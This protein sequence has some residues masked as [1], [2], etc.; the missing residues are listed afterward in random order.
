MKI[1][2]FRGFLL[3]T[4][5]DTPYR[6]WVGSSHLD[7]GLPV[8]WAPRGPLWALARFGHL[9]PGGLSLVV[10]AP[11]TWILEGQALLGP[12][13]LPGL[14]VHLKDEALAG[15]IQGSGEAAPGI[16]YHG[17]EPPRGAAGEAWRRGWTGWVPA[18]GAGWSLPGLGSL[19]KDADPAGGFL[20]GEALVPLGAL[21]HLE[22]ADLAAAISQAQ[23]EL[24]QALSLRLGAGA[25]P[26]AFPFHRRRTGWRVTFLG[27]REAQ[28]AG[29]DWTALAAQASTLLED[30]SR[31]L[32]CPVHAGAGLDF[33]AAAIL[34]HQA[35]R[36]GLPWRG[37]LP[38]PPA[39]ATF[40]PGLGADPREPS[41]LEARAAYP[42]PMAALLGDPPVALLRMPGP[43]G[44]PGA[45]AFAGGL[46][47]PPAICW[48]PPELPPPGPFMTDRTWAPSAAFPPLAD[49]AL[50]RQPSL[51]DP[52]DL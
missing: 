6:G 45:L 49:T 50:A 32:R 9:L 23:A 35:M 21:G 17:A 19:G 3:R 8:Q 37:T 34:G 33:E 14:A 4:G 24:E 46:S 2:E 1:H 13:P 16:W 42:E 26:Q 28:T 25:W 40:S 29:A 15:A 5:L 30:L 31:T 22:H 47:R 52:L 44:E 18:R 27:G 20:W 43:V 12:R 39:G 38:M 41:P 11:G 7:A 10:D 51:F 36:E 48:L